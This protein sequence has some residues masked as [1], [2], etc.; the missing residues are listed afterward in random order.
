MA[1]LRSATLATR[2][3]VLDK[4]R[5]EALNLM[6]LSE[7]MR[8]YVSG[9][10]EANEGYRAFL[11]DSETMR[12]CCT[13]FGRTEFG[14]H[15]VVHIERLD[16]NSG[17]EHP[18]LKAV[19]FVRPSRENIIELKKELR[20]PRYQSYSIFFSNIVNQI[21]QQ[22]L[23]E[24]DAAKELITEVQEF[25]A[26]VVVLDPHL[27]VIPSSSNWELLVQ[28]KGQ[29]FNSS[30]E[31]ELLDR[32]VQGLSALFLA[33]RRR[34]VIRYQRGSDPAHRLADSLYN[35]TYK[36]Q[37]SVFDF[38]TSR[39]TPICLI[40]D[41][42]DDP[43]T[44]L[45]T[46]W[47]Y[48]AMV[49]ELIGIVDNTVTLQT[50]KVDA[51]SRELVLDARQDEFYRKH[52]YANYGEVGVSVKNLVEKFQEQ[53]EKHK[54]VE[55]LEDMRRFV[56]NHSDFQRQ[57][58]NVTKHVNIMTQ[59]SETV[60]QRNL[61]ELS[62]AEQALATPTTSVSAG[63][64]FEDV[65]RLLRS[66]DVQS[67]EMQ[68][69][70]KVRLVMLYALRFE[71][72]VSRIRQ[73]LDILVAS[74]TREREPKMVAA[75]QKLLEYGGSD[76]RAGD[77]YAGRSLLSLVKNKV[78]GLQGVDNV[79][80]QHTPLLVETLTQLTQNTLKP[81]QYPFLAGSQEDV[82]G[83][84]AMFK[85]SPPREAIVFI[86]GG[87]TYEESKAVQEWNEKN[88]STGCRVILGGSTMLRSELFVRALASEGSQNGR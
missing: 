66:S 36:Q 27:F 22:E 4:Q 54:Q 61:L 17:K 73:L 83:M 75:V 62:M 25:Y 81:E 16:K 18:E 47:T 80:T 46:Q 74:G 15:N 40:L 26:D 13:L 33:I 57:Q 78:K 45:L 64:S 9:M 8:A 39:A 6:E 52:M 51:Q 84:Q 28:P 50:E 71:Q 56:M 65:A 43:V 68:D 76:Q 67:T 3:N 2:G 58:S 38:G 42:K 35:L 12:I 53:T 29:S 44:P 19:C 30:S 20:N 82:V 34:P 23:A 1:T 72:E 31:Y 69:V 87:T 24:A 85:R 7:I 60:G 88:A 86:I 55:S 37:Y 32:Y 48:Q 5:N 49:H 70:D 79:Y 14:E 21:Y 11:L 10:I 59:L 41:R 63:P 77:L